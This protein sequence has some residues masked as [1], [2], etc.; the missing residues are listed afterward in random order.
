ME[1][2]LVGGGSLEPWPVSF[3][4]KPC[5]FRLPL[6]SSILLVFLS[7]NLLLL[8]LLPLSLSVNLRYQILHAK[9]NSGVNYHFTTL[10]PSG[11][12]ISVFETLLKKPLCAR[13]GQVGEGAVVWSASLLS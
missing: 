9:A 11:E 5:A 1:A 8:P 4:A 10:P 3:F 12:C 13:P 7:D 6:P 2:F